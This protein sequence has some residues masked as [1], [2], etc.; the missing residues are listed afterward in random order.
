MEAAMSL[1]RFIVLLVF[2]S[3]C[4]ETALALDPLLVEFGWSQPDPVTLPASYVAGVN[5]T[6]WNFVPPPQIISQYPTTEFAGANAV[7][8]WNQSCGYNLCTVSFSNG[9]QH[10]HTTIP[11]TELDYLLG[12]LNHIWADGWDGHS[13]PFGDNLP[14][15][16]TGTWHAATYVYTITAVEREVTA[17]TQTIR[18]YGFETWVPEP[19]TCLLALLGLFA[20]LG[21]SGRSPRRTQ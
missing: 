5:N 10:Y 12:G 21:L 15:A 18:L 13:T 7:N 11:D 6:S 1:L 9:G 2:C 17:T 14:P 4:S 20:H 16:Y 3:L 19:S 8:F